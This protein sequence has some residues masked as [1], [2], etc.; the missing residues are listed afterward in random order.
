[1]TLRNLLETRLAQALQQAGAPSDCPPM[2][3]LATRPEFGD[4]QGTG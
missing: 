4:Y 3:G 2:L 1:M